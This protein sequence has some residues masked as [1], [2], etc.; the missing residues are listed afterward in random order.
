MFLPYLAVSWRARPDWRAG[1][2]LVPVLSQFLPWLLVSR[3]LFLFYMVPVAPFLALGAVYAIRDVA[4]AGASRW[5]TAPATAV[6]A[7]VAVGV[8]VFFWPVLTG[9][10]ISQEA[11]WD[12]IWFYRGEG[13]LPNWV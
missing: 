2:I 13:R 7:V 8:F 4:R 6:M 1:A 3:P 12:R 11:W 10:T 5:I 9:E